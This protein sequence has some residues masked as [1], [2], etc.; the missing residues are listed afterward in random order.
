MKRSLKISLL[1][2]FTA[3]ALG[4]GSAAADHYR[5]Y[6][7][8]PPAP[9]YTRVQ[10]RTGYV[11]VEGRYNWE[12]NQ[13]VWM[14]GHYERARVGYRWVDGNWD[15]RDGRWAWREGRWDRDRDD[16]RYRDDDGRDYDYRDHDR[17]R[18]RDRDHRDHGR[19][20]HRR[21][22]WR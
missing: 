5:G 11:W 19:R 1:T 10:P 12:Y 7:E 20:S 18:D 17:D 22:G 3:L 14:P 4:A 16:N 9:R 15:Q 8:G 13:W 21:G 2:A 6:G